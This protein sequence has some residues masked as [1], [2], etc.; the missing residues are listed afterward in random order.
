MVQKKIPRVKTASGSLIYPISK[1]GEN[2]WLDIRIRNPYK[3]VDTA[4]RTLPAIGSISQLEDFDRGLSD[5]ILM[6]ISRIGLFV[7]SNISDINKSQISRIKEM[8]DRA[9]K[10][11]SEANL[12]LDSWA[13][14]FATESGLVPP[15]PLGSRNNLQEP[16]LSGR[17]RDEDKWKS[18]NLAAIRNIRCAEEVAKKATIRARNI[19]RRGSR[20]FAGMGL[21]QSASNPPGVEASGIRSDKLGSKAWR[22]WYDGNHY[23]PQIMISSSKH[24]G[25]SESL[26]ASDSANGARARL[27][28]RFNSELKI[29]YTNEPAKNDP[30]DILLAKL[31]SVTFGKGDASIA[32]SSDFGDTE[33]I[34]GLLKNEATNSVGLDLGEELDDMESI[35]VDL[36]DK[37]ES[38]ELDGQE[39]AVAE[40]F[41]MHESVAH[42][43]K[44]KKD[45]SVMV[46]GAG[47]IGVLLLSKK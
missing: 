14:G 28:D 16:Y 44:N 12:I 30:H 23:I 20:V 35:E 38:E 22:I 34:G 32:P 40:A 1:C 36:H 24:S 5:E 29:K 11:A 47:V 7:E 9:E 8:L 13:S 26:A 25:V 41:P 42:K 18:L 45:N 3:G 46:L 19:L 10:Y 33:F 43:R 4:Y 6:D 15:S 31:H 27:R 37:M 17:I 2:W 39:Y 21:S